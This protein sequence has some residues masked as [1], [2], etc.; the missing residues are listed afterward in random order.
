MREAHLPRTRGAE[1]RVTA[2]RDAHEGGRVDADSRR[3]VLLLGDSEQL[4][5]RRRRHVSDLRGRYVP[6]D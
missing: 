5:S 1:R 3:R 4:V 2:R 6:D